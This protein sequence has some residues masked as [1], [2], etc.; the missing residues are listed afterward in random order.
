MGADEGAGRIGPAQ[1]SPAEAPGG[2]ESPGAMG[3]DSKKAAG[4]NGFLAR[5][6]GPGGR[7]EERPDRWSAKAGQKER[8]IIPPY[9]YNINAARSYNSNNH[10]N[11]LLLYLLMISVLELS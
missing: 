4:F 3:H 5:S 2:A 9:R 6:A 10:K 7:G 1:P 8:V 11:H